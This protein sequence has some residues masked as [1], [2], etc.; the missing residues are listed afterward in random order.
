MT[1][2]QIERLIKIIKKHTEA[3]EHMGEKID[4]L[5]IKIDAIDEALEEK[6]VRD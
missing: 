5:C 4:D 2:D 1:N 3:M 6:W